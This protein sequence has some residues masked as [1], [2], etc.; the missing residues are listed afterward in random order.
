AP[1]AA[2][3]SD[4]AK[5]LDGAQ[6]AAA[7]AYTEANPQD[8]TEEEQEFLR[9]SQHREAEREKE[10]HA[11]VRRRQI[12]ASIALVIIAVL[13]GLT[14]WALQQ[15]TEAIKQANT[16]ATAEAEAKI[17]AEIAQQKANEAAIAQAEAETQ[18]AIAETARTEAEHQTRQARLALAYQLNTQAEAIRSKKPELS[19]LLSIKAL[20]Q[21]ESPRE[22]TL[23]QA[24]RE[25]L[26]EFTFSLVGH[27]GGINT[28][29]ISPNGHWLAT[30]GDDYTTRLWNLASTPP[31]AAS[32]TLWGHPGAIKVASFSPD[33]H[34]LATSSTDG[35][36]R[37]WDITAPNPASA[38]I[39]LLDSTQAVTTLAFS[40]NNRWLVV[41]SE[42]GLIHLWDITT[43]EHVMTTTVLTGHEASEFG[44]TALAISPDGRWLVTGGGDGTLFR[45]NL[46]MPDIMA[47][48]V[49]LPGHTTRVN[50]LAIS[51]DSRWLVT[52]AAA[53]EKGGE[54]YR[55]DLINPAARPFS[56]TGNIPN[57][58]ATGI[59]PNNIRAVAI[60]SN[61]D[62]TWVAIGGDDTT[63]RLRILSDT[64]TAP[65]VLRQPEE[66]NQII[67]SPDNHWL[68]TGCGDGKIR[69][70]DLIQPEL[71]P[72]V[73]S[74]YDDP[75][76][77]TAMA[78]DRS[79]RWLVAGSASRR[80]L[81]LWDL[82]SPENSIIEPVILPEES[83]GSNALAVTTDS[84]WLMTAGWSNSIQLWDLDQPR[85]VSSA[86][87]LPH[88][89]D[90]INTLAISP[91]NHWLAAGAESGRVYRWDLTQPDIP[92]HTWPAHSHSIKTSVITPDQHWLVTATGDDA[93]IHLW[94]LKSAVAGP[95]LKGHIGAINALAISSDNHQL[96]S[97]GEDQ[98]IRGWRLNNLA[99]PASAFI[100][101]TLAFTTQNRILALAV[102]PNNRWLASSH[103]DGTVRLWNM[104][105]LVPDPERIL[106]CQN[107]IAIRALAISPDNRWLLAG[108]D[109]AIV[110][111]WDLSDPDANPLLLTGHKLPITAVAISPN[112]HWLI[113][114]SPG[115]GIRLWTLPF[116][117]LLQKA[118]RGVG[119]NMTNEEWNVY[120]P[121]QDYQPICSEF[122]VPD[123]V[124]Q[125][126]FQKIDQ[127][128]ASKKETAYATAVTWVVKTSDVEFNHDLC[129][130]GSLDG[131]AATVLPTCER[132]LILGPVNGWLYTSRGVAR[133]ML[134]DTDQA[135]SDFKAAVEWFRQ[136]NLYEVY[137]PLRETWIT[138]LTD[139]RNPFADP[140]IRQAMQS[141]PRPPHR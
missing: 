54:A 11:A 114:G 30:A 28:V 141:D 6:L 117:D 21:I 3:R 125:A 73:L 52:G 71:E 132:A 60:S 79:G 33:D 10:A 67:F 44:V 101:P 110:R 49:A 16:A 15:Q 122:S 123:T 25:T 108:A 107:C 37:L 105:N 139:Q 2:W 43:P 53:S 121:G 137:G 8:V 1:A 130:R 26:T 126:V 111:L 84:R 94:D 34:W 63:V 56:L 32:I 57:I 129:W 87:I 4:P 39:R 42:D 89:N 19:L 81:R 128:P 92:A 68:I 12:Y 55:Y 93:T 113:S 46:T 95:S 31:T 88:A 62:K 102:S 82:S 17:Q 100:T 35:T 29:T 59:H 72:L 5:L 120:F 48:R 50:A 90:T 135:V 58:Q 22:I 124:R 51:P 9:E 41:G 40:P 127:T 140:A 80:T 66:V 83:I 70:W 116:E 74:A 65:I 133:A 36:V 112:K 13:A 20:Q 104:T 18:R 99:Q 69:R 138:E 23:E 134:G 106:R 77:I 45:W 64:S 91:D 119:R 75:V 118:C 14:I 7:A 38:S 98:I 97:G 96:I 76:A 103:N 85:V 24:L 27:T 109:D 131:F 86:L 115:E 136:N 61:S 47:H 78:L